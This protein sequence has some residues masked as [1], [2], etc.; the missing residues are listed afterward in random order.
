MIENTANSRIIEKAKNIIIKEL[1]QDVDFLKAL[2]VPDDV[3]DSEGVL[4]KY[5]FDYHQNP[6]TVEEVQ[7][8]LTIQVHLPEVLH[9][10]PKRITALIEIWIYSHYKNMK[11]DNIPKIRCNR[12]DYISMLLDQ[13][14]NG[15]DDMGIGTV[16]LKGNIEGTFQPDYLFRNMTFEV[17]ATNNS[18]CNNED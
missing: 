8:F 7:T 9:I 11:V 15:R 18:P 12:N 10:D 13:K 5:I 2:N 16:K 17:A 3:I 6:N 1:I 4:N 14:I